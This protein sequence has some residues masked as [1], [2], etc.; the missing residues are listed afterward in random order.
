MSGREN[1]INRLFPQPVSL[2]PRNGPVPAAIGRLGAGKHATLPLRGSETAA[3]DPPTVPQPP[4]Q[5]ACSPKPGGFGAGRLPGTPC[6][7]A[8][9]GRGRFGSRACPAHIFAIRRRPPAEVNMVVDTSHPTRSKLLFLNEQQNAAFD[10]EFHAAEEL[11]AKFLLLERLSE[12]KPFEILDLGGGNGLFVDQLLARFPNSHAT[13]LDVSASLLAKNSPSDR[14]QLIH[15]SIELIP[16]ILAGRRFD[17]ITLNWVLHH[18]VGNSYRACGE[19]CLNTLIQCRERLKPNG[20]LIVTENMFDGYLGSN[21]AAYIIYAITATRWPWFV[22]FAGRFFNTA[23]VG[24]CFRSRRAW[25]Q[26]FAQAG[27]DV[28]AFQQ[29]LVWWWLRRSLR[30]IAFHLL[31][32]KSV[33]HGHFF[34]SAQGRGTS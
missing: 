17:Y 12:G 6:C 15:S 10:T 2:K 21:L 20:L 22:R 28:V 4:R 11:E 14:K 18:L 26:M 31:F 32:V 25:R 23:G 16:D 9:L 33:S 5:I 24:V 3:A 7:L 34:L 19:N 27:F 13:I 30:G 1:T 8:H 29:G